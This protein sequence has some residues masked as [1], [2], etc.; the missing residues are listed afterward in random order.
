ME[1]AVIM[2]QATDQVEAIEE[3]TPMGRECGPI[4]KAIVL[5]LVD[6]FTGQGDVS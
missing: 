3:Q 5:R 2:E 1:N 6:N 4:K